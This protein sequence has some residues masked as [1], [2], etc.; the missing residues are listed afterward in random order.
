M[1]IRVKL[2]EHLPTE[3]KRLFAE[4]GHDAETVLD[5]GLGGAQDEVVAAA[6]ASEERVLVT[7]DL[8]FA[9]I[10]TCPPAEYFGIVVFRLSTAGLPGLRG[11]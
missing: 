2:D 7:Q 4:A 6:C 8:D 3:L 10:R 5:D 1:P 11:Y 9:D